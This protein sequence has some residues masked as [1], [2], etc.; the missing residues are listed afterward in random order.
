MKFPRISIVMPSFNQGV[1]LEEAI[2]S[3]L[4]QHYPNL[5]FMILDGQS[6]DNSQAIIERYASCLAYWQSKPDQGQ[7]DAIVQGM[8]RATGDL[9][10][11][12]NTDDALLPGSL[13]AIA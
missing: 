9:L 12:V 5:E 6:T 4:D 3:I 1:F 11:W 7:S 8:S 13:D 2:R 10:G